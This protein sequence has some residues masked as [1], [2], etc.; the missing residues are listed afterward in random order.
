ME[1][2]SQLVVYFK[3]ASAHTVL[4]RTGTHVK[5]FRPGASVTVRQTTRNTFLP[6]SIP[7][8]IVSFFFL[9]AFTSFLSAL[10]SFFLSF[11]LS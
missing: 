7:G 3:Q 5:A 10:L 6:V 11:F 1:L 9:P 4:E 2:A 8:P